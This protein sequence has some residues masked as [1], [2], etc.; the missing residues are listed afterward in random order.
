MGRF[1]EISM[2]LP[3]AVLAIRNELDLKI[4]SEDYFDIF[5]ENIEESRQIFKDFLHRLEQDNA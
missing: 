1:F 4:A 2:L 3:P 5:N